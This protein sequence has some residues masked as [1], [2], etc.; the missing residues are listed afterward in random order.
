M[1]PPFSGWFGDLLSAAE[2]LRQRA[3]NSSVETAVP[4]TAQHRVVLAER[5][6]ATPVLS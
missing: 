1:D 3:R 4:L 5:A 6:H 2:H